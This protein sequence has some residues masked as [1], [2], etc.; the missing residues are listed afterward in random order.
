MILRKAESTVPT[1]AELEAL[2]RRTGKQPGFM[3]NCSK[4][5]PSICQ[6]AIHANNVKRVIRALEYYRLTGEPDLRSTM[7]RSGRSASRPM[8]FAYFVLNDETGASVPA[9]RA[10][11]RSDAGTGIWWMK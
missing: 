5:D 2:R 10:A 3:R 9:D 7:S 8:H 11:D 4:V 6:E 1:G